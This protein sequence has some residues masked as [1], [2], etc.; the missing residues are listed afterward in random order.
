M[1]SATSIGRFRILRTLGRGAQGEV[2][3]AEDTRLKRRVAIKTL[4]VSGRTN[5]ERT[6]QM[7]AL[8][9]ES[10][11]VSQ[12]AHPNIV[13]L[14][15]AGE[16]QGVPYLVFE[17]VEGQTLQAQI[18]DGGPLPPAR[19]VDLAIQILKGV[20]YAHHK[21][22]VHRDLKPANLM[23]QGEVIRIMD[24][25][26]AQL[27]SQELDNDEAFAGTPAYMAP[28]YIDR[29]IYTTRSDLFSVG[30]V[31]Y[32]MLS[33]K[34]AILGKNVFE[35]LHRMVHE[36]FL[37]P[38][39]VNPAVDERVDDL[40]LRS[41]AKN[42]EDRFASATEMEN[43]L[44]LYLNPEETPDAAAPSDGQQGTLDF[45]L[46]RM[47]HRSDFPALTSTIGAINRAAVSTSDNLTGLASTILKD[48]ALT[49]KLLK[50]VNTVYYRQFGANIS[51]VSRAVMV[52]GYDNT[53]KVALTLMLFE[54]LQNKAQAAHL[55]DEI[56]ASYFCGMLGRLLAQHAQMKDT[57]EAFIS[58]LL[59]SLGK[60]LTA[61]YFHDEYVEIQ[62]LSLAKGY[63]DARASRE[64]LGVTYDDLAVGVAKHWHF[65]ERL[66]DSLRRLP[67]G[68][69]A[70]P[71]TDEQFLRVIADACTELCTAIRNTNPEKRDAAIEHMA[72]RFA[73]ALNLP[74]TE[75]PKL[76]K[77]AYEAL[78]ADTSLLTLRPANSPFYSA[79]KSVASSQQPGEQSKEAATLKAIS[80]TTLGAPASTSLSG[81]A[82]RD[83]LSAGIQDI[84]NCMDGKFE[85]NDVLRMI[86]ETMYRAIGFTR[87]ILC[88]RDSTAN[89]L[90]GRYGFGEGIEELLKGGFHVPL[91]AAKDVFTAALS[92]GIDVLID[93]VNAERIRQL[94]PGWYRNMLPS[95]QSFVLFPVR[96]GPHPVGLFY[97]DS[98]SA[99]ALRIRQADLSLLKALRNQ[100]VLAIRQRS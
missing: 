41:M 95:A 60:L 31:L 61:F 40:V 8:L 81:A 58:S 19:A 7:N 73:E 92:Q 85:L 69:L 55:R 76:I 13:P 57:E 27:V 94:I 18:R 15:D 26:V 59:H 30:M 23:I 6:G 93:D 25:G 21:G 74:K 5:Q 2:F 56:L 47:R 54:H 12:L 33:G 42:P 78:N 91:I 84:N 38:S 71:E 89:R 97:G 90:H 83:I 24:F 100:A 68:K 17:Y 1:A 77:D 3:L 46:R 28:E 14:F 20:G 67:E 35:T 49:N 29:K 96:V 65:P 53:R 34:P 44:Y 75:V 48:F 50:L 87:M 4:Q 82:R 51:T 66:V 62:K 79:L 36:E 52:L 43:A 72:E 63:S 22:I 80:A 37:P 88:V 64:V 16:E 9:E 11:I 86:L 39:E 70:K 10:T 45:L 32:E 99:D 98:D